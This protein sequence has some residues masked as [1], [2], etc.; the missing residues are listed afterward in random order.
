[1]V[2]FPIMNYVLVDLE[3]GGVWEEVGVRVLEGVTD[4]DEVGVCV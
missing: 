3:G 2:N 4:G 1:M